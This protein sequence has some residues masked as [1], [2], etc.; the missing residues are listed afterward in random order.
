M[1]DNSGVGKL[2]IILVV[3]LLASSLM[4]S[5]FLLNIYGVSAAGVTLPQNN[6]INILHSSNQNF[7]T[8]TIDKDVILVAGNWVYIKNIG[9]YV[10]DIG[11]HGWALLTIDKVNPVNN[12]YDNTYWINN[13]K[14]K[15]ILGRS[16]SYSI[17]LRSTGGVDQN[18]LIFDSK[19]I[20]IP[21]YFIDAFTKTGTKYFYSYPDVNKIY[22]AKIRTVYN[23]QKYNE[24]VSVY[25]NDVF[26]F[27]TNQMNID[28]NLFGIW[29]RQFAGVGSYTRWFTLQ[30][31]HTTGT[32][33]DTGTT[34]G[35][36]ALG[37]LVQVLTVILQI[38][39]Y[40]ISTVY[41]PLEWQ[42]ILIGSQEAG[43]IICV[44]VILRG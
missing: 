35:L 17:L 31:F 9:R 22:P 1:A 41:I 44:A 8:D 23:N 38:A 20:T 18:E 2:L 16:G 21:S 29:G 11:I 19:G 3:S 25:L 10:E 37:Q 24:S 40:Q 7:T 30:D 43:I 14:G 5:W 36:D 26:L 39:T 42:I 6:D 27:T 28:Q 15:D 33:Q 32:V 4:I 13:T 34:T 12:L